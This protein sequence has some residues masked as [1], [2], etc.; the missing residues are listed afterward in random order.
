MDKVVRESI[1]TAQREAASP[2]GWRQT[3][4]LQAVKAS[5]HYVRQEVLHVLYQSCGMS[6]S[7]AQACAQ[8][9]FFNQSMALLDLADSNLRSM[10][11]NGAPWIRLPS[12][13]RIQSAVNM[14]SHTNGQANLHMNLYFLYQIA[15]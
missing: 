13:Y 2:R 1:R 11:S 3:N 7:E 6:G 4:Q 15:Q 5:F 10:Q 14:H 12:Q 9:D 8:R